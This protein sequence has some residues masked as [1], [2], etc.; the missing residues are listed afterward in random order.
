MPLLALAR[1]VSGGFSFFRTQL[2]YFVAD[3]LLSRESPSCQV[4]LG[5]ATVRRCL[6]CFF[7]EVEGVS[8]TGCV[9]IEDNKKVRN[10][11]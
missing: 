11:V 10:E 8:L 4:P 3:F 7:V 1:L 6:A 2:I 5:Q 9:A